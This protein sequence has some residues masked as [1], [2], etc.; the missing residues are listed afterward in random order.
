MSA[1]TLPVRRTAEGLLT[2]AAD[3]PEVL[4]A[5]P[6]DTLVAML[7][8]A[9][10]GGR[11][12]AGFPTWR[13]VAA[14]AGSDAPVVVGNGAEG[15]PASAK[16]AALLTVRPHLVMDGLTVLAR[17]L[18]STEVYLYVGPPALVPRLQQVAVARHDSGVD[19]V[20]IRVVAAPAAFLA[21]ETSAVV[22]W[23]SGGAAAPQTTPPHATASGVKGR[24]TLVQNVETLAH[25]ALIARYG[26]AWFA[27][28]GTAD[29]AGSLLLTVGGAVA[30]PGVIEVAHGTPLTEVLDLAGGNTS[31]LSAVLVGGYHG[32]WISAADIPAARMS[33]PGLAGL[34]SSL[35]AGVVVALPVG[36][37]GVIETARVLD[38]LA[39]QSAGQ[40][41]PCLNGM[42]RLATL[43]GT[44]AA[45]AA[46][47]PVLDELRRIAG[48]VDGR[49]ACHHPDGAVRFLRSGL[50]VFGAEIDAHLHGRCSATIRTPILP[51]SG[52]RGR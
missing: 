43:F 23:L 15:E 22:S 38:Y 32:G 35:G 1:L 44:L 6:A 11:G 34:G 25:V 52:S 41:G 12:G 3:R 10:L 7:R 8:E 50:R 9:G 28:R 48:L 19:L 13:K 49:G 33:R 18:R 2:P 37:C 39:G 5:L 20:P 36:C 47:R 4:P 14:I 27:A 42:P 21:G 17:T 45:G 16:D 46:P 26:A 51:T 24:P 30:E 40:C 29:E 31:P